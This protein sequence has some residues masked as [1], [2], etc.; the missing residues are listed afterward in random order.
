MTVLSW[1]KP[2]KIMSTEDWQRISADSAPPG[3]YTP[4]MSEDDMRKWKA[5]YVGGENRRVEIRKTVTGPARKRR[6]P[7]AYLGDT[8]VNYAQLLI[9]VDDQGV[10]MSANGTADFD[11]PEFFNMRMAVAEAMTVLREK[12]T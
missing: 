2:E 4:N 9:I 8:Q 5:K 10:R 11:Y 1:D 6:H 3:V 7:S 12:A